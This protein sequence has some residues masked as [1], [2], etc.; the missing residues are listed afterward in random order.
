MCLIVGL[1]AAV[2]YQGV[3]GGLSPHISHVSPLETFW[4]ISFMT[5][6]AG[7]A[8]NLVGGGLKHCNRSAAADIIDRRCRRMFNLGRNLRPAR[9]S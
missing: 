2:A 5:A 7:I 4:N 1:L 9:P 6:Y 3:L 8:V